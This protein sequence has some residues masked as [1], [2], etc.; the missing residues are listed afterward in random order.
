MGPQPNSNDGACTVGV[1]KLWG[2]RYLDKNTGG[3]GLGGVMAASLKTLAGSD[4]YVSALKLLGTSTSTAFFSG[5]S[6]GQQPT[7]ESGEPPPTEDQY[8]SYGTHHS[9][10]QQQG[11]KFQLFVSTGAVAS[12]STEQ[13]IE[14][15]DQGGANAVAID[16]KSPLVTTR[17]DSWAAIVE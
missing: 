17:V 6:V 16:L 11:G 14:A 15:I 3:E 1:G 12:T 2:M 8:F 7:C 9:L 10:G 13:G 4:P 5:A